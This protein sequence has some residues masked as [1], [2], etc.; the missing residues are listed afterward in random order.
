MSTFTYDITGNIGIVRLNISDIDLTTTVGVRSDWTVLFT[1][2]EIQIFLTRASSDTNLASA[3]ALMAI[4]SSRALLA[5]S[6]R[7][8]DYSEDLS[9]IASELREQAKYF[10]KIA[11]TTPS[12]DFAEQ[13][14]TDFSA[15]DIA[16][17]YEARSS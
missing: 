11:E 7:L 6:K 15:R 12:A 1:D 8:G 10:I 3:Y 16:T 17:N 2:E 4:A 5:K 14:L 9:K 13:V